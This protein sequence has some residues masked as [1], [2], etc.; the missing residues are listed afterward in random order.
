V[1]E[2]ELRFLPNGQ[3][4]PEVTNFD[5][6]VVLQLLE[7]NDYF[8]FERSQYKKNSRRPEWIDAVEV[9]VLNEPPGG[10]P[11]LF[12]LNVTPS[13]LFISAEAREALKESGIRG[14]A[15]Y[16]LNDGYS[17]QDEVDI[18]VPIPT[19]P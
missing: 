14:T 3:P 5:D 1:F 16:S 18:P 6:F 7:R 13:S 4:K 17:L 8:D 10:F 19:Y 9:Y 2:S 15:Y 12:R 11:P